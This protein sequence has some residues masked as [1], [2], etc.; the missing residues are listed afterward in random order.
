MTG[1][2]VCGTQWGDEGKGMAVDLFAENADLIVRYQGGNNAGHTVIVDGD[3]TI[4]HHIPSGI[5]HKHVTCVIGN[6]VVVYPPILLDEIDRLKAKGHFQNEKA[7]VISDRAHVIMPYHTALDMA[8]EKAKGKQAIGTTGRGIGP[9]YRDKA[10][11]GGIR[12]GLLIQPEKFRAHLEKVLPENNFLLEK[13]YNVEPLSLDAVYDEY[14]GYAKRIAPFVKDTSSFINKQITSGKKILFEGAQGAMLDIDHGTYPYVTSSNTTAGAV[15]TGAGVSKHAVDDIYGVVKAYTT[16]VGAGPFPTELSDSVGE[17]L[18]D[19][20]GEYGSTTGRP[21]RCGW[22]DLAVVKYSATLNGLTGIVLTKLDVLDGI[23]PIKVCTG[24]Q[25]GGKNIDYFPSDLDVL[26]QCEP[27]FEELPGWE[28]TVKDARN[29]DQ[30][31]KNAQD[32]VRAIENWLNVPVQIVS[33]GPGRDET[34]VLK[35]PYK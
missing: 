15:F 31:P 8:R 11:R 22:L 16:R 23:D 32:Y 4:L 14:C 24:Y 7:L 29:F 17:K 18:R 35:N 28:D 9:T 1:V 3:K 2:V 25:L 13:Y 26:A 12:F 6:G 19:V 34:I 33:V 27:I 10:G 20:G 5:L 21:R 30:L